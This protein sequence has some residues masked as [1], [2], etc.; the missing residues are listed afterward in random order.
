MKPAPLDSF[1][2]EPKEGPASAAIIWMHGLGAN[3]RDFEEVVPLLKLPDHLRIRF[4]FPNAPAIPVTVNM[5][6]VMPAWYD[7]KE[8]EIDRRPDLVQINRSAKRIAEQIEIQIKAGV[9]ANRIIIAGFSQG[10]VIA[11]HT[12]LLYPQRLAGLIALSSYLPTLDQIKTER[13]SE[14]SD[15]PIFISHGSLDPTVPFALGVA[16]R[17][18][19]RELDYSVEWH[20]YPISHQ[21]AFEQIETMSEFIQT[22]LNATLP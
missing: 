3:G 11:Y 17:D 5:G 22:T 7:I 15:L 21:M 12:A 19:L 10:G 6:M 18:A 1:I 13:A 20:D 9:P 8:M 2:I 4:V 14:N 16:A